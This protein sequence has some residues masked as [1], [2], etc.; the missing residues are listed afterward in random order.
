M[1]TS[2]LI[3][4]IMTWAVILFFTVYFFIKVI[5]IPQEKDE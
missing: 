3:T 2:A 5:K 4:L 1:T